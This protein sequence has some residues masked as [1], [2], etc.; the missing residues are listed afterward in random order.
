MENRNT[1]YVLIDKT[2]DPVYGAVQGGHAVAEWLLYE[3]ELRF[4]KFTS[5]DYPHWRWNNDYLVYLKVD[6]NAWYNLL[7]EEHCIYQE[8]REPDLENK[9]TAIAIHE[10]DLS[11]FTKHMIK[12]EEL[13]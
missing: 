7:K 10:S 1:L 2:L 8:F 4:N 5:E 9:I 6:I 12:K 11:E 3:Y 13:L